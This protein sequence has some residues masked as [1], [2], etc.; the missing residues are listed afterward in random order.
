MRRNMATTSRNVH[1]SG[2]NAWRRKERTVV[3]WKRRGGQGR[4]CYGDVM[5]KYVFGA[6]EMAGDAI[7]VSLAEP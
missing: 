4:K 6:R 1:V 5:Y 2:G 3:F 7:F